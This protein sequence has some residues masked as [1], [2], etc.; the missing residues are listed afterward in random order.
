VL[1]GPSASGAESLYDHLNH[2][3]EGST[4]TSPGGT[5][6]T[7]PSRSAQ[8]LRQLPAAPLQQAAWGVPLATARDPQYEEAN[9]VDDE[10]VVDEPIALHQDRLL[11]QSLPQGLQTYESMS[12]LY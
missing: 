6:H 11:T 3:A 7:L 8:V 4:I 9:F 5:L 10:L 1:H 12:L 2:E